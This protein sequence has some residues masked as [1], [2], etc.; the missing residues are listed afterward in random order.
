[1]LNFKNMTNIKTQ[2]KPYNFNKGL[3]MKHIKIFRQAL[4]LVLLVSFVSCDDFLNVTDLDD[5]D[6]TTTFQTEEDMTMALNHLYL[7]LP[8]ADLEDNLWASDPDQAYFVPYFW[9]D[10]AVH[11]NINGAGYNGSDYSWSS[12]TR[13]LRTFYRYNDIADINFFLENLPDVSFDLAST[14]NQYEAEARFFRAWIYES[15]CF[16][17]GGVPLVT[18]LLDPSDQPARDDREDVFDYVISELDEIVDMLP[19][20]YDADNE[21]RITSGAALA[22]KARAY[23][24][25]IGWHDDV[26]AMY[27]GAA[28]AC[29]E[30][31]S[32]G[33]YALSDGIEGYENQFNGEEDLVSTETVLAR[34]YIEDGESGETASRICRQLN[35]K[36]AWTGTNSSGVGQRRPGFSSDFIEEVQTIN[37]L[38]PADDPEYDPTDPWT[39]RD[40]RLAV[41]AILSGDT[42]PSSSSADDD[43]IFQPHPDISPSTDNISGLNCPTGYAFK[44]YVDYDL[45]DQ[46]YGT[47]DLK[48]IR[49]SEVLLMYAE[50]MAGQGDDATALTYLDMVR[51]RV[52]MPKYADI[53]LP[54]VTRGTTGNDMIDAIL[55][56]RRYEFAGEGPQRWFDIFRYKLA[57]QVI[58]SVYGIPQ[59]SSKPGDL[60]G[61]KYSAGLS[62]GFEREWPDDD[63]YYLLPIWST[64]MDDNENLVQNSGY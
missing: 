24:N 5:I 48:L 17:Y 53:G 44:K 61:D 11:R 42:V 41:C 46:Y 6:I 15:M 14:K 16:A 26:D 49:Y 50:A 58:T 38:F 37:G 25:A 12:S 52:G 23:L 57:D 30:I 33:V 27:E 47:I 64:F 29:E 18:T 31:I 13:C 19:E 34:I 43:Y 54:T 3:I 39:N 9:T 32:S 59:D 28:E 45:S 36:G 8:E 1:M 2:R 62:T 7:S 20:S 40:P 22:L 60:T 10:D 21:G 55:L 4:L 63:H 51:D 56:E 35:L